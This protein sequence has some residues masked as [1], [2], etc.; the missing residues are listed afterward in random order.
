MLVVT[1]GACAP[2]PMKLIDPGFSMKIYNIPKE[3]IITQKSIGDTLVDSKYRLVGR[4]LI[5]EEDIFSPGAG[6]LDYTVKKGAAF[7]YS[8]IDGD[9]CYGKF[10]AIQT[11]TLL[12]IDYDYFAFVCIMKKP[13]NGK[14]AYWVLHEIKEDVQIKYSFQ[15]DANAPIQQTSFKQ[16]FIYNGR[17]DNAVKFI[18]RE[19]DEGVNRSTFQQDL[20]YDLSES[21]IIGFKELRLEVIEATN[22]NI[23]YKVLNNFSLKSYE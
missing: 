5:L 12:N 9:I 17:V 6:I 19:F 20:Q 3:N 14:N 13:I 15:D 2:I 8:I 11:D 22:Q 4:A 18:Y 21:N 10:D 7:K 16:K 23:T 1:L